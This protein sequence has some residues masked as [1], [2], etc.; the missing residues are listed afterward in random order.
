MAPLCSEFR[1]NAF[2]A[3]GHQVG[4]KLRLRHTTKAVVQE[5]PKKDVRKPR[6]ENV[7]LDKKGAFFVD[8]T[9]IGELPISRRRSKITI[10]LSNESCS[11]YAAI[12]FNSSPPCTALNTSM[13]PSNAWAT[14]SGISRLT[15]SCIAVFPDCDTCRYMAPEF[16]KRKN[17]QSAV[18]TQ[19]QTQEERLQA[20]QALLSCPT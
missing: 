1:K 16:F 6:P 2:L 15:A 3:A 13:G 7:G 14:G 11:I 8:H 12:A 9:C 18:L 5:P 10:L 4:P 20:F 17:S 19:P